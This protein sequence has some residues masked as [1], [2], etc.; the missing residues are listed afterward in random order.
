[1]IIPGSIISLFTFPGVIVHEIAHQLF[2]RLCGLTVFEVCYFRFGTPAGYI[3][4]EKPKTT[5]QSLIVGM[6]PMILNTLIGIFLA[7]PAVYRYTN[8]NTITVLDVFLMW[9]AASVAMHS[10]PSI[11]DTKEIREAINDPMAPNS[12]KAIGKP[13]VGT[14]Y[15]LAIGSFFWLDLIYGVLVVTLIPWLIVKM[16]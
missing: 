12:V 4:H 1:M 15:L 7:V 16:T 2:C 14:L 13:L 9:L 10:F 5:Y 8:L 6:G 11:G 3:V